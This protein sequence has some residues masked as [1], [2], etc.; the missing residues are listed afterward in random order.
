MP[1]KFYISVLKEKNNMKKL[2]IMLMFVLVFNTF[3][4]AEENFYNVKSGISYSN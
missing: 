3:S 1:K 2:V 4:F